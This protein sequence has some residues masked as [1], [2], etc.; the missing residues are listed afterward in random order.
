MSEGSDIICSFH[1]PRAPLQLLIICDGGCRENAVMWLQLPSA[2]SRLAGTIAS[3][4][5][6]TQAGVNDCTSLE[7]GI[8][9]LPLISAHVTGFAGGGSP[10]P[11]AVFLPFH[12]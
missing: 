2:F 10:Y 1:L 5:P 6:Y 11:S 4:H 7:R 12:R 3:C 9:H 8:G